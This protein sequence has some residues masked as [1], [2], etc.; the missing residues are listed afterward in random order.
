MSGN[1]DPN[2]AYNQSY[3]QTKMRDPHTGSPLPGH[4]DYKSSSNG[5][6][7]KCFAMGTMIW[8]ARG[9]RPIEEV[10]V[11]DLVWS[12][13]GAGLAALK[14]VIQRLDHAPTRLWLIAFD[15]GSVIRTTSNHSFRCEGKW[16]RAADLCIGD[17]IESQ[18]PD[19]SIRHKSITRST[20]GAEVLPVYN[21]VV[22]DNFTFYAAGMLVH[23][24][25][26]L[27]SLAI[28]YWNLVQASRKFLRRPTQLP[29]PAS[30]TV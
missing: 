20:I 17:R 14:P 11:G 10:A 29:L 15:D 9:H 3:R 16:R 21:L 22:A 26:R 25:T 13:N 27:R 7:S 2:D 24:F 1:K 30:P 6:S 28:A 23:S 4:P 19:A 8:T 18:S 5:S 12:R